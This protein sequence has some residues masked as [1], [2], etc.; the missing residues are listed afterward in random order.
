MNYKLLLKS[1]WILFFIQSMSIYAT[2]IN[3]N[4]NCT[5]CTGFGP[6]L[7]VGDT[8]VIKYQLNDNLQKNVTI[9]TKDSLFFPGC[10]NYDGINANTL[11]PF[12]LPFFGTNYF[13]S[14]YNLISIDSI[15]SYII[16][17][18]VPPICSNKRFALAWNKLPQNLG[19]GG[20]I[21][22]V[23]IT[24]FTI[25]NNSISCPNS[26]TLPP[27][28]ASNNNISI[29]PGPSSFK[30]FITDTLLINNSA[31]L[32]DYVSLIVDW[33]DG[34][35]SDTIIDQLNNLGGLH[36]SDPNKFIFNILLGGMPQNMTSPFS[37]TYTSPV[38][39]SSIS[40]ITVKYNFSDTRCTP[41][42]FSNYYI[43]FSQ[44]IY[45]IPLQNIVN[46][47]DNL[48]FNESIITTYPNPT[49]G[50]LNINSSIAI[51]KID[52]IN[53]IGQI[54]IQKNVV[55]YNTVIDLNSLQDNIYFVQLHTKQ[56]LV[57]KK[58]IKQ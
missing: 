19:C 48:L 46:K 14:F 28:L 40:A 12:E 35:I 10:T 39:T 27:P 44:R 23:H 47:I 21:F 32:G 8:V 17:Y 9:L 56:G 52:V 13:N 57:T 25:L 45:C 30:L 1:I 26:V 22:S 20:V 49:N 11:I 41:L 38:S 3:Y 51:T 36:P 33:G 6:D 15:T 7:Y 55:A 42:T 34:S 43:N 31:N 58:I 50:L 5:A 29:L 18:Q 2:K 4:I 37:H 53:T 54:V 24:P 16:P